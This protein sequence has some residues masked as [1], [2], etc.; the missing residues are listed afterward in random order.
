MYLTGLWT[1]TLALTSS[2]LAL[3]SSETLPNPSLE[4]RWHYGYIGTY[5]LNDCTGKWNAGPRPE[6]KDGCVQYTPG[7]GY[8]GM[9]PQTPSFSLLLQDV[10][11]ERF[12][13]F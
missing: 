6:I 1:A 11:I 10:T 2:A 9:H 12:T 8:I 3:P 13:S 5:D 4:K 7:P